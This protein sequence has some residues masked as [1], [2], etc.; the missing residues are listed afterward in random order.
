[1]PS[2][3]PGMDPYIEGQKWRDFHLRLIS[4]VSDLLVPILQ[5]RYVVQV[6]ERIY[7]Q[8]DIDDKRH[9]IEP[10]LLLSRSKESRINKPKVGGRAVATIEPY[11]ITLPM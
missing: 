4:G 9:F 8:H 2:P 10:D 5:P 1:M 11:E 3:F 6:E 7:L